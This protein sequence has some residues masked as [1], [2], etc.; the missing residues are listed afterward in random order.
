METVKIIFKNK[1]AI[2]AELN[3]NC[4]VTDEEPSFPTDLSLVIVEDSAGNEK[5]RFNY[6]EITEAASVDG[7]YWWVFTETPENVRAMRQLQANLEYIAM[8]TDVELDEEE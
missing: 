8:M 2:I 4:F 3:G 1:T 5:Q 7:R 6:A